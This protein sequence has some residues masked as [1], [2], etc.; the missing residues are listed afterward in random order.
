MDTYRH[1]VI[2]SEKCFVTQPTLSM[3]I[4]KLEDELDVIIF[5]R[6]K[7]PVVPTEAGKLI[8]EQAKVVIHEAKKIPAICQEI[9]ERVE[10]EL[11]I[12]IIPTVVPFLLPIFLDHFNLKYPGIRLNFSEITTNEIIDRLIKNRLDCGILATPLNNPQIIEIPMY[13]EEF[14]LYTSP[15]HSLLQN[16]EVSTNLIDYDNLWLLNESHCLRS[17]VIN[18]CDIRGKEIKAKLNYEVGSIE[19]LKNWLI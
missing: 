3:M 9:K 16:N 6:S 8:I 1:F 10:G 2:A 19:T 14:L 15:G 13:Y 17:Q 18:F 7:Q 12:G 5:D 11:N 4:R